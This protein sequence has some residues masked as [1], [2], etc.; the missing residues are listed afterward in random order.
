MW[1]TPRRKKRFCPLFSRLLSRF[2]PLTAIGLIAAAAI[3]YTN[4]AQ[5]VVAGIVTSLMLIGGV[6]VVFYLLTDIIDSFYMRGYTE[7]ADTPVQTLRKGGLYRSVLGLVLILASLP[8]HALAWGVAIQRSFGYVAVIA[9]WIYRRRYAVF[10][11]GYGFVCAD[12]SQSAISL[13]VFCKQPCA[14]ISC[15]IHG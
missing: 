9:G 5:F 7:D 10:Q 13:R 6:Y 15:P 8:F 11:L 4:L 1:S 12:F 2:W 14:I 3:G